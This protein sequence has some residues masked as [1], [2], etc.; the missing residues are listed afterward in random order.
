MDPVWQK[1]RAYARC[2]HFAQR[3]SGIGSLAF[4][5]FKSSTKVLKP[6]TVREPAEEKRSGPGLPPINVETEGRITRMFAGERERVRA[7]LRDEIGYNLPIRENPAEI[8]R[9]RSLLP[10]E[11]P[12]FAVL[13][14]SKGRMDKQEEAVHLAKIDWRGA[15]ASAGFA[16]SPSKH[17]SWMPRRRTET[18][19]MTR[20]RG[21]WPG[22]R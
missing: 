8:E 6:D 11:L 3:G 4:G 19:L 2:G 21:W 22:N 10:A 13:K 1:K 20:L 14:M 12:A 16:W 7:I 18:T 9:I 15:L 5:N 17:K